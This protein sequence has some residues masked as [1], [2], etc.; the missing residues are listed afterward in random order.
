MAIMH[1]GAIVYKGA[2]VDALEELRG[3]VWQKSIEREDLP[4]YKA[5]LQVISEKMVGGKPQIHVLSDTDPGE[6]FEQVAPNLEDVFF[7]RTHAYVS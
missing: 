6:G 7:T 3:K 1:Q 4:T 5:Q 2:P